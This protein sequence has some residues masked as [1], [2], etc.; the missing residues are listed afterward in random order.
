MKPPPSILDLT[1]GNRAVWFDKNHRAVVYLDLR[2]EVNPDIV[3]DIRRLPR[4]VGNGFKLVVFDPP[5]MCCGPKSAMAAR[6]GHHLTD[7]IL[8][9]IEDAA[10]EAHRVTC[11]GAFM[12]FKWNTHDIPWSRTLRRLQRWW[13]PLFGHTVGVRTKHTSNT[14]WAMLLRRDEVA[15]RARLRLVHERRALV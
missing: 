13:E 11:D 5:H 8:D 3:A 7:E 1:S 12:A 10:R 2:P 14:F 6:Y 4:S 9:T 15:R